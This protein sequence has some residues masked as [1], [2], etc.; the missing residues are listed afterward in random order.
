MPCHPLVRYAGRWAGSHVHAARGGLSRKAT[1]TCLQH[2]HPAPCRVNLLPRR[3]P[4]HRRRRHLLLTKNINL[5]NKTIITYNNKRNSA[6]IVRPS[7]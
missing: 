4:S 3:L 1:E 5:K 6:S 2:A 7:V